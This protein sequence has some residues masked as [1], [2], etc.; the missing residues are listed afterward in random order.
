VSARC[1]PLTAQLARQFMHPSPSGDAS[2]EKTLGQ[3]VTEVKI[4]G[5]W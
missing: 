1:E 4:G 2:H 3:Q 5:Y